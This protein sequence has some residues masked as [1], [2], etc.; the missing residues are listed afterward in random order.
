MQCSGC[1]VVSRFLAADTSK[2]ENVPKFKNSWFVSSV[3]SLLF[4]CG[5]KFAIIVFC[6]FSPSPGAPLAAYLYHYE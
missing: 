4:D 3:F 5:V 6:L 1:A 2:E